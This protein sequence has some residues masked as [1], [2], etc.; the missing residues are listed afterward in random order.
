MKRIRQFFYKDQ[1]GYL[2][3]FPFYILFFLF[4]LL[5]VFINLG[6]SFT[7][8]NFRTIQFIGFK[9][10]QV[11]MRDTKFLT[12][13]GNTFHY[14]IYSVGFT[15]VL[16]FFLALLMNVNNRVMHVCRAAFYVPHV[17]SMVAVSMVWLLMY[18]S[19]YG[20]LNKLM[21]MIGLPQQTW[22]LDPKL[23]M[24]CL[25]VMGVWKGLGYNI[26]LFLAG[27]QGVPQELYEA[28]AIDG[29]NRR[30]SLVHITLPS[31]NSVTFF[32][33]INAC[34]NSFSVFDQVNV[35]TGGGP[36]DTTTTV[37]HQIY[38][39]SFSEFRVGYG[40][41]IAVCLVLVV[42]VCTMLS[43]RLSHQNEIH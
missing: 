16:S 19:Y 40:A 18:N 20:I 3:I 33:V 36:L 23:S 11:L 38:T 8:Y 13:I 32:I 22:L 21:N 10:Y 7:S 26:M 9:N 2:M 43:F 6:L 28:A 41:A 34:I 25:I 39:R 1:V 17:A 15:L 14:A 5:P 12:S 4:I 35:M 29:A 42:F 37:V 27:L 24:A 30:Q 31:L